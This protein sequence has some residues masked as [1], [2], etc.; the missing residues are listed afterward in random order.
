MVVAR[1]REANLDVVAV[2]VRSGR[3]TRPAISHPSVPEM[4]AI[5][6]SAMPDSISS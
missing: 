1:G 6:A 2:I 4:I 3:S 5:M